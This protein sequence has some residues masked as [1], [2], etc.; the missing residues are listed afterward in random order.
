MDANGNTALSFA[1]IAVAAGRE[2]PGILGRPEI[3]NPLSPP[4]GLL[5]LR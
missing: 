3:V 4:R 5:P 1:A 2:M